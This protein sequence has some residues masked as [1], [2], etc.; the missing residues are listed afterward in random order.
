MAVRVITDFGKEQ[1]WALEI[2]GVSISPNYTVCIAARGW[3]VER[4]VQPPRS[5]PQRLIVQSLPPQKDFPADPRAHSL[6]SSPPLP[7]LV[8]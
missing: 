8:C 4:A 6:E 7:V 1:S 2:G 5:S 3:S